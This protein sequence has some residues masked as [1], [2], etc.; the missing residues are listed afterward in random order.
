MSLKL[1]FHP[2]S[3][4]MQSRLFRTMSFAVVVLLLP[5]IVHAQ[6]TGEEIDVNVLDHGESVAPSKAGTFLNGYRRTIAGELI[7]YRS[8]HPDA[9]IALLVR[10]RMETHSISWA[11]DTVPEIYQGQQYRFIWLAGLEREGFQNPNEVHSF[12]LFVNGDRWFTFKNLKDSTAKLWTV[13]SAN[14]A[15]LSFEATMVDRAGDLFGNMYLSVPKRLAVPGKPLTLQVV[16]ENAGSGDWCMTFQYSFSF[17]PRVRVEPALLREQNR[18]SQ[19]LRLSLDNLNEG[20]T[21]QIT[22]GSRVMAPRPLQVGANVFYVSVDASNTRKMIPVFFAINGKPISRRYATLDPVKRREIYLLSYSHNDIGYT[23]L[24]PNIEKKQ[25]RNLVEALRI[26]KR[27]KDYP[28]GARYKWNMEV[29]WSLDGYLR[30][31]TDSMRA[32][33]MQA[34]RDGSIGLNAFYA[35]VLTGLAGAVEMNHL[36]EFARSLENTSAVPITTALVSDVPGFSWGVVSSLAQS[37]V[38]YFSSSP[39][40]GDRIGYTL[41]DWGDKPF[42]W[43]SQSGKE[44]ILMW[45]AGASYA[46]FH[47]GSLSKLGD[48]KVFKMLR[49][50]D[51]TNYPYQIV[52]MPYTVGGDNGPPDPE[53]PDFVKRWNEKYASPRLI[54]ATHEQM[55]RD[56]ERRYGSAL[57]T[58]SGDFTPYWE[59]GAASSAFETA[60]N[61]Q[62][63][64]RL[65][66]SEALWAMRAPELYPE[67]EFAAAWRNVILY[68]EH[69]WGAYNSI[70]EP[71]LPFVKGQWAIKRNFA[72]D[73]DSL[74]R[75]LL[76]R[77]VPP[78]EGHQKSG[79]AFDVYNTQSW[80]R[81][82]IVYLTREN[83]S[84]GDLV[85]DEAGNRI[86][87]QRLSSGELVIFIKDL[88]P[89]CAKRFFVKKGGAFT[90]GN[91]S[92]SG[93]TV[94]NGLL[95]LSVN[96]KNG[97]IESLL[98]KRNGLQL[99]DVGDWAGLNEFLYVPGKNPEDAKSLSNVSVT[100]KERGKLVSSLLVRGD[101]PGCKS[102]SYEARVYDGIGRI[103]LI[104]E[105]DKDTVRAKEGVH[106]AFP[107]SIQDGQLRYDVA[108]SVVRPDSDQLPGSCKNFF[109][110]QSWVDV[111]NDQRGITWA[112]PDAP[113]IEIGAIN[114]E[115]PWMKKTGS[116]QTFFSYVMNNYW[117][118]NYKA[119]QGGETTFRYSILPHGVFE[120]AEA[121]KFGIEQRQPLVVTPAESSRILNRPLFEL[122]PATVVMLSTRP[123]PREHAWL[124]L[125]YNPT[126]LPRT[127]TLHWNR[128]VKVSMCLSDGFGRNG[129]EVENSLE[130]AA[131]GSCYVRVNRK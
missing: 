2:R 3:S 78:Q 30:Q 98:W 106:I 38:R 62:A 58:Y 105:F 50:L 31:A 10:A 91:V 41:D 99:V 117:H 125:L 71:D 46:S 69:T 88:A 11:T 126:N 44:K 100:V 110:V 40:S 120:G 22:A 29:L 24:Q 101:A 17:E 14:G 73:A 119:D 122:E 26:I 68:D 61:R 67:N 83:S 82:D 13:R 4:I 115:K 1:T 95:S 32:E 87:S 53:L 23:D 16:G 72:V 63:A 102:F 116:T 80:P 93:H 15:E 104:D 111:S 124:L 84:V 57:P 118:T 28:E 74:S 12:D 109:S 7:S 20:R 56:F 9:E 107:F 121:T 79:N 76:R 5:A 65:S 47:E 123:L 96:Q 43:L 8:S 113:L 114:A 70:S 131:Y 66:Q 48:E 129:D 27:T 75:D 19:L 18:E 112:S 33:V 59:D 25:W 89:M 37:G 127:V 64:D 21:V 55:F 108:F 42:Y 35:N 60:E 34:I 36:T 39:N 90:E 49:K 86:P 92:V 77:I 103:D 97:A 45:V 51:E 6:Q 130:V 52:Q 81:T 128:D 85:I 94:R 54:I